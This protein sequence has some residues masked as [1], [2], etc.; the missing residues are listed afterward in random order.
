MFQNPEIHRPGTKPVH[1]FFFHVCAWNYRSLKCSFNDTIPE[2][3]L[4]S[5][6]PICDILD[7]TALDLFIVTLV[8]QIN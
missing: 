5:D 3:V 2:S 7:Q 4:W 6:S 8:L 1:L